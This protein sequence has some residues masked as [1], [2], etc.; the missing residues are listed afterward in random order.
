MARKILI[1]DDEVHI[2]T[3]LE[4]ALEE[5]EEACDLEIYTAGDGEEGLSVI[6]A[7]RPD[8]VFLD[9][10]MPKINGYEVCRAVKEDPEIQDTIVVVLTAKSQEVDRRKG[11]E[12]GA[13]DYITKPFDPDEVVDMAARLLGLDV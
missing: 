12:L 3:L 11:L 6:R 2:R 13:A 5:L 1:V 9:I 8:V 4:Q 10:M 7:Q